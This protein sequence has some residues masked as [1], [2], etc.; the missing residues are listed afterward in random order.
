MFPCP[1]RRSAAYPAA[2]RGGVNNRD[3]M[4]QEAKARGII[5]PAQH[6]ALLALQREWSG[7]G[8]MPGDCLAELN[9]GNNAEDDAQDS[10]SREM[11]RFVRGF[12]D[13]IIAI[14]MI[15]VA[16]GLRMFFPTPALIPLAVVLAEIFVRRQR[17]A[18][19][20][21][22]LTLIFMFG[23]FALAG[24][25]LDG[26]PPETEAPLLLAI[27]CAA[28]A[29][30]Y[31]RYRAPVALACLLASGVGALFTLT[32]TAIAAASDGDYIQI[33]AAYPRLV[34]VVSFGFAL[35]AF[36]IAMR[37]DTLDPERATRRSDVA[38]WLHLMTAPALLCS[39]SL[40]IFHD[41]GLLW[42]LNG[43][44]NAVVAIAI[45]ACMMLLG[46]VIDRRAF[47]TSGLIS[48]G[49]AVYYMFARQSGFEEWFQATAFSLVVVGLVVLSLGSC[50]RASRGL[51][52]PRLPLALQAKLPPVQQ[53][54]RAKPGPA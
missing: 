54:P 48:L 3:D 22:I 31:W 52:V 30:F 10:R 35:L 7:A 37:F 6:D 17:L 23:S 34:G 9:Q 25:L 40:L 44:L 24:R 41:V 8:H 2:L 1:R 5:S 42:T 28:L 51:I 46:I 16:V 11:P 50:W 49:A 53:T 4:L 12:H 47:V 19:P 20:A 29:L 45:V 38:F 36:A 32:L 18:L 13:V 26:V 21:F 15:L 27:G 14:G 43:A 39:L 33:G